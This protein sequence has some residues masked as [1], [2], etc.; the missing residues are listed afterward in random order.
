MQ[1][2]PAQ[3]T[4]REIGMPRTH[5]I[6]ARAGKVAVNETGV[7]SRRTLKDGLRR[8]HSG[9][10]AAAE[11]RAVPDDVIR[12]AAEICAYHSAARQSDNVPV[13]YTLAKYVHK[14][15][16]ARPGMVVYTTYETAY[17]TPSEE[18]VKQL[19]RR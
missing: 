12:R 5:G 18:L 3:G 15:A 4:T 11:G 6:P 7:V 17:V 8:G 13:D 2:R 1:T 10:D 14:P 16:G 9:P 19:K